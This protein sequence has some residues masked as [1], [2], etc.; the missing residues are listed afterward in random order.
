MKNYFNIKEHIHIRTCTHTHI[1]THKYI[2]TLITSHT[3]HTSHALHTLHYI[4]DIHYITYITCTTFIAY[5][6]YITCVTYITYFTYIDNKYIRLRTL[7]TLHT[8]DYIHYIHFIHYTHDMT[9]HYTTLNIFL[10][11]TQSRLFS[12][13]L[14]WVLQLLEATTPSPWRDIAW[15]KGRNAW[16]RCHHRRSRISDPRGQILT[17]R[18]KHGDLPFS[19]IMSRY[20]GFISA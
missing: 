19:K 13:L 12:L 18:T 10:W 7:H 17:E 9:W 15:R 1:H 8:L 5:I 4:H 14:R 3:L 2:H 16:R 20:Y 11:W 6:A